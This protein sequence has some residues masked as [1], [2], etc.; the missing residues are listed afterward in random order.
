MSKNE[1]LIRKRCE[2]HAAQHLVGRRIVAVRYMT[3]SEIRTLMWARAALVLVLDDGTA[4]YPQSDDEG[5]DA[6][7]LAG[8]S[9][10]KD[11]DLLFGSI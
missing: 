10:E 7:A 9:A 2:E 8:F 1:N 3:P 4:I 5:N 6:G 11:E